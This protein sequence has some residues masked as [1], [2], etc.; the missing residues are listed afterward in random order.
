[1]LYVILMVLALPIFADQFEIIEKIPV[2]KEAR[3]SGGG[4]WTDW[5]YCAVN[6]DGNQAA[7]INPGSGEVLTFT[8]KNEGADAVAANYQAGDY[9]FF[10][11]NAEIE[12]FDFEG[13]VKTAARNGRKRNEVNLPLAV[14]CTPTGEL[15]ISDMGSRR[16]LHFGDGGVLQ[17]SFIL[18]GQL[19]APNEIRL[20]PGGLYVA[21]GLNL[22]TTS[23]INAGNFCT[24]FS[25]AGEIIRSFAYSPP[26]AIDRNLWVGVSAVMDIDEKGM[27]Y[28]SFSVEGDIYVYDISG[29]LVRRFNYRPDWFTPPPA[30]ERPVFKFEREPIGFWKSW[31]R[32]IGLVYAGNGVMLLVAETNGQ[33]PGV[34]APFIIDVLTTDGKVIC[35]GIAWDYW[36]VGRADDNHIYWMAYSGDHLIKTRLQ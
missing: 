32:I 20:H 27:I 28:I 35:D 4:G 21:A 25:S 19:A 14:D 23:A 15:L 31:T 24:V 10:F 2:P 11:S 6:P 7:V 36:P 16:I 3:V 9:K 8:F 13:W 26:I 5:S 12:S 17:N 33:V 34:E 22:D 18:T 29:Q 1:M 30:L